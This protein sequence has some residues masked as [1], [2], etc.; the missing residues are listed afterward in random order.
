MKK[1]KKLKKMRKMRK[2][3]SIKDYFV[4]RSKVV[5]IVKEVIACDV[6]PVGVFTFWDLYTVDMRYNHV[7]QLLPI[8]LAPG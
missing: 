8:S 6:S 2:M 3:K 7:G 1:I 5:E 4:M